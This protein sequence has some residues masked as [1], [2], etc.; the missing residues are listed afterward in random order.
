MRATATRLER[1]QRQ[2]DARCTAADAYTR[3]EQGR[4][5]AMT[6]E[7]LQAHIVALMG[8]VTMMIEAGAWSVEET[9]ERIGVTAAEMLDIMAGHVA[10]G[11]VSY[12]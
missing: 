11:E 12:V 1:L 8:V 6:D 3:H 9:A 5:A 10:E 4:I 2:V 7:Q